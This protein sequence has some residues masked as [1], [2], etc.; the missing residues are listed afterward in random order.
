MAPSSVTT[1]LFQ[2]KLAS[3]ADVPASWKNIN[4]VLAATPTG[5]FATDWTPN[6][7]ATT[8]INVR[9]VPNTGAGD[10]KTVTVLGSDAKTVELST[11]GALGIYQDAT[12]GGHVAIH[13]TSS[14]AGSVTILDQ[15]NG[16]TGSATSVKGTDG[17]SR[18]K[19]V[20]DYANGDYTYSTGTEGDQVALTAEMGTAPV[21]GPPAVPGTQTDDS[22][23]STF[24]VQTVGSVSATPKQ[25]KVAGT[26]GTTSATVTVLDQNQKPVAGADVRFLKDTDT[27]DN[28]PASDSG[29]HG[30]TD[31]DGKA[32]ISGLG[33]GTW[34]AYVDRDSNGAHNAGDKDAAPFTISEYSPQLSNVSISN[35]PKGSSFD[36]D[37]MD[38]TTFAITTTDN[39]SNAYD[40]TVQYRWSVDPNAAGAAN[41][42]TDWS[43]PAA[44][45]DGEYDAPFDVNP[46]NYKTAAGTPLTELPAGSYTLEARH[47]NVNGTGLM[48]ATPATYEVNESE[49]TW[50][51]GN[52]ANAPVN[53][54]FTA[55]GHLALVDGGS[56][57][58]GRTV[59]VTLSR[60]TGGDATLVP[61]ADQ[62]SGTT[63]SGDTAT[64][65]TDANG[66][67]KVTVKDQP[68][69]AN[70]PPT[71]ESDTLDAKAD[72]LIGNVGQVDTL[73]TND[74]ADSEGVLTVNFQQQPQVGRVEVSTSTTQFFGGD[75][76]PG[77]PVAVDVTVFGKDSD[78]N[79]SNDPILKDFPATV[80]V[81][82]GFLTKDAA[83]VDSL[84]LADGHKAAGDL[85]GFYVNQ[86][87]S[88]DIST[89]DQ[90]TSAET[91]AA[92]EKD[93]GFDDDGLVDMTITVKAGDVTKT[94]TVTFNAGNALNLGEIKFQR[95]SGSPAG[96]ATVGQSVEFNL[97]AKDQFGNLVGGKTA[98]ISDDST[99]ADFETDGPYDETETDFSTSGAGIRAFS[100]APAVQTLMAML[101][102]ESN[103]V[104]ADG[105]DDR[106]ASK[107][108]SAKS[109]AINWVA[110]PVEPSPRLN[111][112]DNGPKDDHLKVN[113][114][115]GSAGKTVKLFKIKNGVRKVIAKAVLNDKGDYRFTVADKNG[116]KRTKYVAKV[117]GHVHQG[118]ESNGKSVR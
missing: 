84:T 36:F 46:A 1:L 61:T 60:G 100:N 114:A 23:A 55:T 79:P 78:T 113:A 3:D 74:D 42:T 94:K 40:T 50:T 108:Y 67:F 107:T 9:A 49:I 82:K 31:A 28:T 15:L 20:L 22:E 93:S 68:V 56:S 69:P 51:D 104:D 27:T 38:D 43:A 97:F 33:K 96:D 52:S 63:V 110:G 115:P 26:G 5:A 21:V 39:E 75:A 112:R 16:V 118:L 83:D 88:Q 70:V 99:V 6:L 102:N 34:T 19:G 57:L 35:D 101:T 98:S 109:D 65:K 32:T 58:A 106:T 80:S 4:G 105:N 92:I 37:E 116:N 25:T 66:D 13:G 44:T 47:P 76:A 117:L 86:G 89:G 91:V 87:Q 7:T 11:E 71:A 85:F 59:T 111:G 81:D 45:T 8:A 41:A 54:T 77:K 53:G 17:V 30:T 24:Y 14:D 103:V 90:G 73:P 12:G 95:T 72:A 48:N 2:Y 62:P 10:M 64:A 29:L 18:F